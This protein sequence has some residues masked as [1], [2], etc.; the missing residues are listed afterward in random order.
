[1][2]STTSPATKAGKGNDYKIIG[3][4]LL[5]DVQ[6]RVA[7]PVLGCIVMFGVADKDLLI[8]AVVG[9]SQCPRKDIGRYIGVVRCILKVPIWVGIVV[10]ANAQNIGFGLGLTGQG[11]N[12]DRRRRTLDPVLVKG[13]GGEDDGIARAGVGQFHPAKMCNINGSYSLREERSEDGPRGRDGTSLSFR[14]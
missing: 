9:L 12:S 13:V 14:T 7:N 3:T 1:M 8:N 11:R 5:C 10:H 6:D 4:A 2:I